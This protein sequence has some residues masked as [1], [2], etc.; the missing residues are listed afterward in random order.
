[1]V[2]TNAVQTGEVNRF[3]QRFTEHGSQVEQCF[4]QGCCYWFAWVLTE[5][6]PGSEIV[7]DAIGNHFA[8]KIGGRAYDI[9]G[10][11]TE[12]AL[13]PWEPWSGYEVGS[14][15]RAGIVRNCIMFTEAEEE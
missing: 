7:Y 15:C 9:T 12:K 8:A 11:V 1:M 6:F 2:P 4:T 14:T 3:I 5:R 10:D 13:S